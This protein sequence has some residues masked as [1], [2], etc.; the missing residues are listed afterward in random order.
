MGNIKF[1]TLIV[2]FLIVSQFGLSIKSYSKDKSKY[3]SLKISIDKSISIRLINKIELLHKSENFNP[4]GFTDSITRMFIMNWDNLLPGTYNLKLKTV[5]DD[6]KE[7]KIS[8]SN[9]TSFTLKNI[10]DSLDVEN[11]NPFTNADK[12][13]IFYKSDGCTHDYKEKIC[14]ERLSDNKYYC[15]LINDSIAYTDTMRRVM[16]LEIPIYKKRLTDNSILKNLFDLI[17][18]SN[19]LQESVKQNGG[20]CFSTTRRKL[21]VLCNNKIFQF[22]DSGICKWN[23][24]NNFKEIYFKSD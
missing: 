16:V 6:L 14:I 24:Y 21:F 13:S 11:L 2:S 7:Y 17:N 22:S 23:L 19:R 10:Y 12:I 1:R 3:C 15:T 4:D 8:I 18:T 20:N 5:F 9:D